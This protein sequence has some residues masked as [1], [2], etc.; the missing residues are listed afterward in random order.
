MVL[1][2][3]LAV[4]RKDARM[5]ATALLALVGLGERANHQ[6]AQMSGGQQQRAAITRA[7]VQ[8]PPLVLADDPTAHID[9]IR[10]EGTLWLLRN[11]ACPGR[12]LVV[13]THDERISLL[14]HK[15]VEMTPHLTAAQ[16]EPRQVTLGAGRFLFRQGSPSDLVHVVQSGEIEIVRERV[17]ERRSM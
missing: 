12:M 15:V 5:G 3:L 4:S 1:L 11:L 10:V 14:A 2:R 17:T 9:Y 13:A 6:P 8:D 16:R 7:L